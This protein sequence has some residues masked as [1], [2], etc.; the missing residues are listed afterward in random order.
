MAINWDKINEQMLIYKDNSASES[1]RE[2]ARTYVWSKLYSPEACRAFLKRARKDDTDNPDSPAPQLRRSERFE[3]KFMDEFLDFVN[4]QIENYDPQKNPNFAAWFQQYFKWRK[5]SIFKKQDIFEA[6]TESLNDPLPGEEE[7]LKLIDAIPAEDNEAVI[8]GIDS[9]VSNLLLMAKTVRLKRKTAD[10]ARAV[11][12]C[13]YMSM[14]Y[15]DTVCYSVIDHMDI[16]S[17]LSKHNADVFKAIDAD[18][19]DFVTVEEY[20]EIIKL[21]NARLKRMQE[22]PGLET[23]SGEV[24]LPLELK[25]YSAFMKS[26]GT[27]ADISTISKRRDKYKDEWREILQKED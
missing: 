11:A 13:K 27:P 3:E 15:T 22:L 1:E 9:V 21:V 7:D 18:L 2:K 16:A 20:R 4:N 5:K 8:T 26:E 24:M 17:P 19:L 23:E 6:N 25:V 14:F 12:G 10:G